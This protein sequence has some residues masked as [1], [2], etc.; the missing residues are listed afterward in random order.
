MA[1]MNYPVR[2]I[3]FQDLE[4]ETFDCTEPTVYAVLRDGVRFEFLVKRERSSRQAV[5]FGT[6]TMFALR[7]KWPLFSRHT[8]MED[9]PCNCIYYFDPTLYLGNIML[10]WGYGTKDRWFLREIADILGVLF[11]KMGI[12][13]GDALMMGSSG[14]GFTSIMLATLLRSRC[15]A[16]NPQTDF[17]R[18]QKEIVQSLKDTILKPEEDWIEER[19]SA[20]SLMKSEGYCPYLHIVQN[21]LVKHDI[22]HH[23]TMLIRELCNAGINCG[24]DRVRID[25]FYDKGGHGAMPPKE[26]C[27]EYIRQ[28]LNAEYS[29][30][31]LLQEQNTSPGKE[32]GEPDAPPDCT[33]EYELRGNE[34][35]VRIKPGRSLS[36]WTEYAYYLY[37]GKLAVEKSG[38]SHETE[39][40]YRELPHGR[41]YVKC[42][43]MAGNRKQSFAMKEI[44]IP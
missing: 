31:K 25:F 17:R 2:E 41:Y 29:D 6:G 32:S 11:E 40:T 22:A 30:E 18:Y 35:T 26:T 27:L 3:K 15:L 39:K 33:A 14:G 16:V 42:Y 12:Q 19:A 20:V 5:V 43:I 28:D 9:I 1:D 10:A 38:Y 13:A 23:L 24:S 21:I 4:T 36:R 8:W 37:R 34:L 44:T 7:D